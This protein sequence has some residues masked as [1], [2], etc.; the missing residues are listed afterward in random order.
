MS[1]LG[2]STLW[3]GIKT[4]T[5]KPLYCQMSVLSSVVTVLRTPVNGRGRRPSG[6][7]KE[8]EQLMEHQQN[9]QVSFEMLFSLFSFHLEITRNH[10]Q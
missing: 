4:E 9:A 10:A 8:L 3:K 7:E 6:G 2:N 1:N 5:V